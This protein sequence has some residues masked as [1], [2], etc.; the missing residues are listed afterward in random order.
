[1]RAISNNSLF[2]RLYESVDEYTSP[3]I[4]HLHVCNPEQL[5]IFR[6]L[7]V[8]QGVHQST[9]QTPPTR[10]QCM[11]AIRNN[12]SFL[13]LFQ[14]GRQDSS[15]FPRVDNSCRQSGTTPCLQGS[16]ELVNETFPSWLT[17]GV[18]GGMEYGREEGL[19]NERPQIDH[20]I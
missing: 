2:L 17:R 12:S 19:T 10:G 18:E 16:S 13:G 9:R 15:E 5:L 7:R 6:A 3:P 11:Y 14:A 20:M 4:K 8:G 1:M